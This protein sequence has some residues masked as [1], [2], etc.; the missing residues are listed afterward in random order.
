MNHSLLIKSAQA[1]L[2]GISLQLV[3]RRS[4]AHFFFFPEAL[5]TFRLLNLSCSCLDEVLDKLFPTTATKKGS[6]GFCPQSV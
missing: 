3:K 1:L 5:T 6:N 4:L 2:I